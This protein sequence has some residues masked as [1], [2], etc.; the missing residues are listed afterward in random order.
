[1]NAI[2]P[3]PPS[4][5]PFWVVA[6][7]GVRTDAHLQRMAPE[8]TL[9]AFQEAAR[10]NAAIELDVM[11]TADNRV[12]VHHDNL[13][14][15]IFALPGEPKTIAET[16]WA[17]LRNAQLNPAGHEA[18][19]ARMLNNTGEYQTPE[20]FRAVR[21]PELQDVLTAL[22]TTHLFVE[23]KPNTIHE[24]T[25]TENTL[26][27]IRAHQAQ[28]RVTLISFDPRCLR[29]AKQVA[30]ELKTA[31]NCTI[32]ERWQNNVP[33]LWLFT[34]LYIKNW[35]KADG[36]QPD[37]DSATPALIQQGKAAGLQV[38]PWVSGQTREEEAAAF[39]RLIA[40]G[41]DG[42]ITN[43]VDLLNEALQTVQTR[44]PNAPDV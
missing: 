8:N 15:R 12:I 43:A 32:P 5:R 11:S 3:T 34:H 19:V 31:L 20:A 30:P 33:F 29:M 14:G 7:R 18:S 36:I 35:L 40:S 37:Y 13:T 1:M 44:P 26:N 28:E 9:P 21:I 16:P 41:V 25:L 2:K 6:H 10:Q 23:I 27:I 39:P 22:P 4:H 17:E 24:S 38:V 42:L